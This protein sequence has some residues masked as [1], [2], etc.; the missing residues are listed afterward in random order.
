MWTMWTFILVL[1]VLDA[2]AG[3][4]TVPLQGCTISTVNQDHVLLK[5]PV[6]YGEVSV[7]GQL[8]SFQLLFDTGSSKLWLPSSFCSDAACEFHKR[9]TPASLPLMEEDTVRGERAYFASGELMG[10]E[11]NESICLGGLAGSFCA[12]TKIMAAMEESDYPF[13]DMPFDGILGQ[14]LQIKYVALREEEL[15]KHVN[16]ISAVDVTSLASKGVDQLLLRQRGEELQRICDEILAKRPTGINGQPSHKSH[17]GHKDQRNGSA[18][19]ESGWLLA[20]LF[21]VALTLPYYVCVSY[22]SWFVDEGFAIYRNPDAK[23]ET[24][25]MQAPTWVG[26]GSDVLRNDFW[27]TSLNPPEGYITHKSWRPLITLMY[28]AEWLLC[29]RYGFQ[30]MEM[31]PMRLIS[32][33]VHS[34]N[35]ALVLLALRLASLPLGWSCLGASIFAAHPIHIEPWQLGIPS[36]Y[37]LLATLN[38]LSGLCK[39]PG[40]TALFYIFCVETSL[41]LEKQVSGLN[42]GK[43]LAFRCRW[44]HVSM[45]LGLFVVLAALRTWYVGGT[46]AGFGYVDTPIKYQDART[47]GTEAKALLDLRLQL[48]LAAYLAISATATAALRLRRQAPSLLLGLGLI[49]VPF[50]PMSNLFFLVGTTIG[51]RL[52]YPLTVKVLHAKASELQAKGDLVEALEHYQRSLDI[53][54]D[55]AITDYCIARILINLDR[56]QEGAAC[57]IRQPFGPEDAQG[58]NYLQEGLRRMPYSSYAWNAL[59]VAQARQGQLPEALESLSQGLQVEPENPVIWSNMATI[60][61]FG[62]ASLGPSHD[63]PIRSLQQHGIS[64]FAFKLGTPSCSFAGQAAFGDLH[65]LPPWAVTEGLI[66]APLMPEAE[67]E[68]YWLLEILSM[69]SPKS[70]RNS[71]QKSD[72]VSSAMSLIFTCSL[73]GEDLVLACGNPSNVAEHLEFAVPDTKTEHS[74]YKASERP[75]RQD[76]DSIWFSCDEFVAK[77]TPRVE[78]EAKTEEPSEVSSDSTDVEVDADKE[79][80][81]FRVVPRDVDARVQELHRRLEDVEMDPT[82][83][84]SIEKLGGYP[85]CYWRFLRSCN[86]D[87]KAAETKLRA[88]LRFRQR[89][90][91]DHLLCTEKP[92]QVFEKLKDAWPEVWIGTTSDGSPVSFFDVGKAVRF[93]QL[94]VQEEEL[95]LFWMVWMERSNQQQRQGLGKASGSGSIDP[96]DMPG[97]VVIYDLKELHLSQLTSCLSGLHSLIKVLGLAEKHYPSNLRKAVVLNAP[98]VFSR[99]VW[100]LVHKVLDAETRKDVLVCDALDEGFSSQLGF[101]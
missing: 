59:G 76:R 51:E 39:E 99:M 57:D 13:V 46:D 38:V 65:D 3:L 78:A 12:T 25:V 28:A 58:A 97:T 95:R 37:V 27:G 64:A 14:S 84:G 67:E 40:F 22:R 19:K 4:V 43:E 82:A 30:G 20:C 7:G 11:V 31:Q 5:S 70:T 45:L 44:R 87:V 15:L 23:G 56:F 68:G 21:V 86:N 41:Q 98:A 100:P 96:H 101:G 49:V 72:N 24:P 32:C 77:G 88:T 53:F 60:Y 69:S 54:D 91:V 79:M 80:S 66:W 73:L 16:A 83:A 26:E 85:T 18:Q 34:L 6:Y 63:G 94:G 92:K 47:Y 50:V 71:H 33:V 9:Y 35:S 93:L 48:I 36:C 8:A 10:F 89:L 17:K 52:L 42:L 29:A 75:P 81:T 55:Q 74:D 61:A 2:V 62:Q 90:G 1:E